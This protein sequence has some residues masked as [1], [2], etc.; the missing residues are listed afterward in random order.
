MTAQEWYQK[1]K[2]QSL[3][4]PGV[5]EADKGQCVQA[6]DYALNEI[7]NL[8]YIYGNN[9]ID[10]W[11]NF[12]NI[13][14][15]KNNFVKVSDGSVKQGSFV[16]FNEKTGSPFGHIDIALID[17]STSSFRGADSNWGGDKTLHE[18]THEGA[19][20]VIGSL[21]HKGEDMPVP[22]DLGTGRM[23]Y[24]YMLGRNGENGKPNA[25]TGECDAEIQKSFVGTPLTNESIAANIYS[26]PEC[27]A[28]TN[29][30]LP[31]IY[32]EASVSN[33]KAY[34]GPQL[35]LKG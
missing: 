10:W 20:Y 9:A 4:V 16:I 22:I 1:R 19:Q 11:N 24:F 14:Q 15:L 25:L 12:D 29:V 28:F 31:N 23:L 13:P 5:P 30:E 2:G 7:Y 3:L 32:K 8:P 17:A 6:A 35:Y 33:V 34:D 27:Q 18:V 21:R 26:S